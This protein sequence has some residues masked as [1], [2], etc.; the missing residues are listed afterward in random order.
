VSKAP[1][2]EEVCANRGA[3]EEEPRSPAAGVRKRLSGT[4]VGAVGMEGE[5][6]T[7]APGE[8]ELGEN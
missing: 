4:P 5:F 2:P 1:V 7:I 6:V 8:A 3:R